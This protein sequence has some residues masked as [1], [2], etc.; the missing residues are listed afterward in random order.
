MLS[1]FIFFDLLIIFLLSEYLIYN[2][3]N[4]SIIFDLKLSLYFHQNF[5][6]TRIL[7]SF[8]DKDYINTERI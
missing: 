3:F 1:D 5:L 6:I 8:F 7:E 4:L 2:S